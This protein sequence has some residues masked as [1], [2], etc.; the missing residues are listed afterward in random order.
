MYG[1]YRVLV[2]KTSYFCRGSTYFMACVALTQ[3]ACIHSL[4]HSH[5]QRCEA[6]LKAIAVILDGAGAL[7]LS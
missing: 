3:T 4:A 1:G 2:T 7:G 5:A 6:N